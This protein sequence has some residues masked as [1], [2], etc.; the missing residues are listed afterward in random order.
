MV[1]Y[2]KYRVFCIFVGERRW[3]HSGVTRSRDQGP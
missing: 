2:E 3:G 1:F